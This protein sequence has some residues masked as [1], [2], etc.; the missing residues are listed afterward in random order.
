MYT[1]AMSFPLHDQEFFKTN[2]LESNFL[3]PALSRG[4]QDPSTV[5]HT[6]RLWMKPVVTAV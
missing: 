5:C 4:D 3:R 2:G 1:R 6:D